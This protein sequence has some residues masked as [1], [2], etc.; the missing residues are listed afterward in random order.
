MLHDD[1]PGVAAYEP[2]AHGLHDPATAPLYC[3]TGQLAHAVEL[4][5]LYCPDGQLLH[6][7]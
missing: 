4:P 3:P 1:S 7:P 6:A 5:G 2:A